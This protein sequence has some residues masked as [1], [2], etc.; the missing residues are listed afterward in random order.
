MD[1]ITTASAQRARRDG[2]AGKS[3]LQRCSECYIIQRIR[4]TRTS[5][6]PYADLLTLQDT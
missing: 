5:V 3:A 1:V 2:M 6:R 4:S